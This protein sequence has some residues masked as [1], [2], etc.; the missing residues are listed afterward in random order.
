MYILYLFHMFLRKIDME[1]LSEMPSFFLIF[2]RM[3]F[4]LCSDMFKTF[5]ISF[6]EKFISSMAHILF[7][8]TSRSGYLRLIRSMK[9]L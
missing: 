2:E 7:S 4:T 1:I 6:V 9:S 3:L 5:A 8:E